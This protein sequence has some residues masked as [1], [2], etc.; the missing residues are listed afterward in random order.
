MHEIIAV[1]LGSGLNLN[2]NLF[3]QGGSLPDKLKEVE[4]PLVGHLTCRI[5]YFPYS[6]TD[7]MICAGET[8]KDS[9][10]GDS[11]GPMVYFDD[12]G[13]AVSLIIPLIRGFLFTSHYFK[14]K[15]YNL[16]PYLMISRLVHVHVLSTEYSAQ[17]FQY[18]KITGDKF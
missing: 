10:Q 3:Q 16:P 1:K 18:A 12:S 11:G 4:V 5:E 6:I 15:L 14:G 7:G 13:E 2:L 17:Q 9:C 8:G